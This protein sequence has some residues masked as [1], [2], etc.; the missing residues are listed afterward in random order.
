MKAQALLL[1]I[2]V[3]SFTTGN[4][5]QINEDISSEDAVNYPIIHNSDDSK[6]DVMSSN[7]FISSSSSSSENHRKNYT[8]I[9][10]EIDDLIKQN[11]DLKFNDNDLFDIDEPKEFNEDNDAQHELFDNENNEYQEENIDDEEDVENTN[12]RRLLAT[13]NRKHV[14]PVKMTVD[15]EFD[16]YIN[17]K[18]IG[19]GNHWTTTYSFRPSFSKVYTIAVDGR[20]RGGPAAFIGVFNGRPTRAREW[21]CKEYNGRLQRNWLSPDYDDSR[22]PSAHSYG[23]NN[24]NTV[25]R[26]VSGRT[27]HSIP[28]NAE[29]IWT[30]NNNNHNRVVCRRTLIKSTK[31]R[32]LKIRTGYNKINSYLASMRTEIK[33]DIRM[34]NRLDRKTR[35][36]INNYN[37][38]V[39]NLENAI[40]RTEKQLENAKRLNRKYVN[41]Y[42]KNNRHKNT[43]MASLRRQRSFISV[44][45]AYINK[46][47]REALS[48]KRT[49]PHYKAIHREI[50]QMRNQMKKEIKDVEA[51]YARA[52]ATYNSK[53]SNLSRKQRSNTTRIRNLSRMISQYRTKHKQVQKLVVRIY[54]TKGINSYVLKA[55]NNLNRASNTFYS[56]VKDMSKR[57]MMLNYRAGYNQCVKETQRIKAFYRRA[58]CT[59]K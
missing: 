2:T 12:S 48:L 43:L 50:T 25:W 51:A 30:R 23:R 14:F 36:K 15:N 45:H 35:N 19:S 13:R 38:Q 1:L 52:L 7:D 3:A 5:V 34:S 46:M 10:D 58:K 22:W 20:D 39:D 59:R 27:R 55:L 9:D 56:H 4:A 21:K 17:G 40:T 28:S 32:V 31:F 41:D 47:E 37:S 53:K 11:E 57:N 6:N 54:K 18:K 33:N 42:N 8:S 24:Q 16:L 44:E 26:R 49:S 29:W